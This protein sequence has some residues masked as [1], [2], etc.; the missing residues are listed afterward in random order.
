[1]V[2]MVAHYRGG[3]VEQPG[4]L[5]VGFAIEELLEEVG[6]VAAASGDELLLDGGA[7]FRGERGTKSVVVE[8]LR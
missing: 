1:M 8:T 4:D 5:G 7:L 2:E 6:V 3:V